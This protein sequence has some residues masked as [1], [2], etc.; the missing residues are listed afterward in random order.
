[1]SDDFVETTIL[2]EQPPKEPTLN[3]QNDKNNIDFLK[4]TLAAKYK[5]TGNT[6]GRIDGIIARYDN[7]IELNRKNDQTLSTVQD[8]LKVAMAQIEISQAVIR[9]LRKQNV[10]LENQLQQNGRALR[11]V[12]L[13][14]PEVPGTASA[15]T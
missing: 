10:A 3:E 8:S 4:N 1:M 5:Q 14:Q 12:D 2:P 7:L 15:G 11:A 6:R 13:P 9:H